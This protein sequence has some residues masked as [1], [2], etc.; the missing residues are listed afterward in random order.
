MRLA[1]RT[2]NSPM[3]WRPLVAGVWVLA[4]AC[5]SDASG[6]A[7]SDEGARAAPSFDVTAVT[8]VI[9]G[10]G[11]SMGSVAF[12]VSCTEEAS[13]S[14]RLGLALLHNMTYTEAASAFEQAAEQDPACALAHWG[15]AMTYLHPLWP[16]V[17]S[18]EHL[19]RGW[20]RLQQAR[21]VGLETAREEDYVAALE[22]YYRDARERPEP[23][24]LASYADEWERVRSARPDDPEA[25][26]FAALS[27]IATAPG[28]DSPMEKWEAAGG[29]AER[30]LA[31][32]PDHP[33]AHHYIIHSYDVPQLADR[34]LPAARSY[35]K[36]APE[37][38]HALH[39]TSHIFTRVGSWEES[40]D[41][42]T[43]SADAAAQ[44]PINGATSHHHL[45]AVDYLAYA[46]LQRAQ[47]DRAEEVLDHLAALE[48]PVVDH[49]ASA[50]AFAAV[51]ARIA[52]ERQDWERAAAVQARWPASV[53]WDR[54]PHLEAIP[55]FARALGAAHTGDIE[56]AERAVARLGELE[57]AAAALP[58]S[59]DWGTQVEIQ[60]VA[61][62]AWVAYA[63]DHT[64]DGLALMTEA[65][66]LESGTTK[67]PVTPGEALPA[68]ELLGDMLLDLGQYEEAQRA[69]E[70]ALER[71]PNRFNSLYGAA[72]AAELGGDDGTA[73]EHYRQLLSVTA[74]G[75]EAR[76]GLKHARE[77]LS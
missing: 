19:E 47:D 69:Y 66:M 74:E 60:R 68:T 54:Y 52:L 22:A 53:D 63:Q 35:G 12:P 42:N 41:Y 76:P 75:A 73:A 34:A 18:D 59:Y 3:I 49:A 58:D 9:D 30:V 14:M 39:M 33:G 28:S 13:A 23:A 70:K 2:W 26:L 1:R 31:A 6:G 40:I 56:T 55:E 24:R 45:H 5:G 15:V 36:V 57:V 11:A 65:A 62:Q 8:E 48:G 64:E 21:S 43:R 25:T 71:S 20:E 37:N 17:P 10:T 61:A 4:T 44:H 67:N 27:L 46:Y 32:I 29:A 38:A 72:R 50:Y 16:D 7:E 51:P 77:F